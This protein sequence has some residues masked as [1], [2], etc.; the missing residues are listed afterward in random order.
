MILIN[1]EGKERHL[2]EDEFKVIL[3]L[4]ELD[5]GIDSAEMYK[6]LRGLVQ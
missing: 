1:N 2:T 3:L 4:L 5:N 6:H